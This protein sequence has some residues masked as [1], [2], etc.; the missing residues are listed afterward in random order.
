MKEPVPVYGVVPPLALTVTEAVPP[1]QEIVPAEE[2]AE[3]TVGC[4]IVPAVTEVHP[5]ASV[6]V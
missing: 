4:V 1:L 6:T 2:E 3:R 5:L